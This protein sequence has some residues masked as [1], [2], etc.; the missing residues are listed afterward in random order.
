MKEL[1]T[2]GLR[3]SKHESFYSVENQKLDEKVN[4]YIYGDIGTRLKLFIPTLSSHHTTPSV[5][6]ASHGAYLSSLTP[7]CPTQ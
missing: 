7:K 3:N 5:G 1:D 6:S 2:I 4:V